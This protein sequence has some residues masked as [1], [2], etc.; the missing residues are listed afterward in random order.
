MVARVRCF[1]FAKLI[2]RAWIRYYIGRENLRGGENISSENDRIEEW[3][4]RKFKTRWKITQISSFVENPVRVFNKKSVWH[5]LFAFIQSLEPMYFSLSRSNISL[6]FL[7]RSTT[8][9]VGRHD[10]Y[11]CKLESIRSYVNKIYIFYTKIRNISINP[12]VNS[13]SK[14]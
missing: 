4:F 3:K 2:D 5:V 11:K 13:T 1:L 10:I 8:N 14:L 9:R 7:T 12:I 6:P